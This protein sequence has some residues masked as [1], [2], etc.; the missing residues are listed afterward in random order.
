MAFVGFYL[1]PARLS[2]SVAGDHSPGRVFFNFPKTAFACRMSFTG[3][4]MKSAENGMTAHKKE[5]LKAAKEITVK[6]IETGRI[7]PSN[8]AQFFPEIY[9]VVDDSV[10]AASQSE[11]E[12]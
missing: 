2:A 10:S 6:F 12:N 3:I 8:F 5:V 4:F 1:F 9:R 7:S 11:P